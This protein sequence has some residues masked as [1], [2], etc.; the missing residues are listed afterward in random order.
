M[1]KILTKNINRIEKSI[2]KSYTEYNDYPIPSWIEISLIEFCN[3]KCVFCPKTN[4][5]IAP[6][7]KNLFMPL[8]LI[9]KIKKDLSDINFKGTIVFAGY[10]EP[11]FSPIFFNVLKTLA[12]KFTVEV[13]TNGDLLTYESIKQMLLYD[14]SLINVSIYDKS[15][16]VSL[17]RLLNQ[18]PKNKFMLRDRWYGSEKDFGVKLT[19]RAGTVN[20]GNQIEVKQSSCYYPFYSMTLDWN[21]DVLLCPQDWQRRIKMGNVSL[22][23]I[24]EIWTSDTYKKYRISLFK[25]NRKYLPCSLCNCEGTIHGKKHAKNWLKYYGCM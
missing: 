19:N 9:E 7:Q 11:L 5:E 17:T 15:K 22:N 20:I 2:N 18:F 25:G 1:L 14:I 13:A 10:G 4:N 3:R 12:E 24:N 16:M 8:K 23:T 6:N 21:G